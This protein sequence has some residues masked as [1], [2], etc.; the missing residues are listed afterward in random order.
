MD[1][2]S[3]VLGSFVRIQLEA[4][5]RLVQEPKREERAFWREVKGTHR[6]ERHKVQSNKVDNRI[7]K[8]VQIPLQRPPQR[9]PWLPTSSQ[10]SPGC[11]ETSPRCRTGQLDSLLDR[12]GQGLRVGALDGLD[13]RAVL[14]NHKGGHGPDTILGRDLALVI[15]VDLGERDALR[16]GVLGRET[17][18]SRC[19]HLA[20]AAPVGVEVGHDDGGLEDLPPFGRGADVHCHVR[21]WSLG[22]DRVVEE[23]V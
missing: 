17:F 14:E 18:E 3:R 13:G 21:G 22:D 9:L 23:L 8:V 11:T 2:E 16:L 15:N 20:R 6:E 10:R 5:Q 4:P 7:E 1:V 19:N 12:G